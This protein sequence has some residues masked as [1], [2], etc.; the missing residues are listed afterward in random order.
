MEKKIK[1]YIKALLVALVPLAFSAC[2]F[3]GPLAFF[4]M[5][6]NEDK[7]YIPLEILNEM[8][9]T[10]RPLSTVPMEREDA[11]G[12]FDAVCDRLQNYYDAN[13]GKLIWNDLCFDISL[14]NTTD[15]KGT[16]QGLLVKS[17][18]ITYSNE[19]E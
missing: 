13:K 9:E 10:N 17:R 15:Y 8:D 19:K 1:Q 12:L 16:G 5:V 18:I 11:I 3:N 6:V 4:E 7:T 14:F 2:E